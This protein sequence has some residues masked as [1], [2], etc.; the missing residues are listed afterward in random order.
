[1]H[2]AVNK[3]KDKVKEPSGASGPFIFFYWVIMVKKTG[4]I[5]RMKKIES[6][7]KWPFYIFALGLLWGQSLLFSQTFAYRGQFSSWLTG[8]FDN[9][10]VSQVGIRYIPELSIRKTLGESLS[11][12]AELSFDID[13]TGTFSDVDILDLDG[14]VKPYRFW[15]RF[16]GNRFEARIGLQKINFGSA[17]LFRPLRWFDRMDPRDPLKRTEGVYGLLMRYYFSNNANGWLWG[18]YGNN[19]I[20]G[21]ESIPTENNGIEFGGRLQLPFLTGETGFTYHHRRADPSRISGPALFSNT[22]PFSEHRFA[23]DLKLDIT[24]GL[25]FEA[26][27]IQRNTDMHLMKHQRMWTLGADYTL[28]IGNGLTVLTEFSRTDNSNTFLGTGENFSFWGLSANY[29]VGLFDQVS[30]IYYFDLGQKEHYLSLNWQRT[31][32]NWQFHFSV[33]LNPEFGLLNQVQRESGEF[34][35]KG[36]RIMVV[37]TH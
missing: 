36:F 17:T 34:P 3:G 14:R 1:M 25:W 6:F 7:G 9:P 29:L 22:R 19:E 11:L 30:A 28:G 15:A 4:T 20:K 23:L 5:M 35:G 33:F 24:I 26:A 37:F 10:V 13:G 31:T 12:D 21:W 27:I 32:D 2:P 18:L 16:G 8:A